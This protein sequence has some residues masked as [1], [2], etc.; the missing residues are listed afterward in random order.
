MPRIDDL[1]DQLKGSCIFSKIDLRSSYHQLRVKEEGIP[2]VVFHTRYSHYEFLVMSFGLTNASNFFIDL[3][4]QIF[5]EYVD[6]FVVLFV[7]DILTYS[8]SKEKLE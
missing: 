6:C 1:F 3:M 8:P 4:N 7:D 2:K 5:R